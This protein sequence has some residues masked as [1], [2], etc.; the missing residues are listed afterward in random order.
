MKQAALFE[1][2]QSNFADRRTI[3]VCSL[4]RRCNSN[5]SLSSAKY[6]SGAFTYVGLCRP[7]DHHRQQSN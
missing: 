7:F 1:Q 3:P 4:K 2:P 5:L 6:A